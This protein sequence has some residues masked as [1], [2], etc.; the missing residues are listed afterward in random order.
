MREYAVRDEGE[1]YG[2]MYALHFAG[3]IL[4]ACDGQRHAL[5]QLMQAHALKDEQPM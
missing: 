1:M 5:L 2:C 4:S 3:K